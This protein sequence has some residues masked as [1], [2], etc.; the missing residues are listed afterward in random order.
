MKFLAV[1]HHERTRPGVFRDAIEDAGHEIDIWCMPDATGA[2]N[3]ERYAGVIVFG[4]NMHVDQEAEHPWLRE[5]DAFLRD[6]LAS[7]IPTLGICL[8]A[9]L[10]VKALG[11]RVFGAAEPELGWT[12]VELDV[13]AADDLVIGVLPR[14]FPALNWHVDTWALPERDRAMQLARSARYPQAFRVGPSAWGVQFHPELTRPQI[15]SFLEREVSD[16]REREAMWREIDAGMDEWNALGRSL[17]R[18]FVS[19]SVAVTRR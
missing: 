3:V 4:G 14:H 12:H 18:A 10:L 8:G 7:R 1:T 19:S 17:C 9:Q 2:P 6:L 16:H 5:E 13:A 11:G 15:R